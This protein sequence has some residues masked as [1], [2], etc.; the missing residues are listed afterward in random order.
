MGDVEQVSTD[1]QRVSTAP[2]GVHPKIKKE[3]KREKKKRTHAG[4]SSRVAK[5][6]LNTQKTSMQYGLADSLVRSLTRHSTL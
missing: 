2:N 1:Y 3:K 5:Q 6:L 4:L